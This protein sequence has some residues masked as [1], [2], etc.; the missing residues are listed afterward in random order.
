MLNR[1]SKASLRTLSGTR[2]LVVLLGGQTVAALAGLAY[3]KLTA[4]Y[5]SPAEWGD[6]SLLFVA[7]TLLHSLF[8]TPTLQWFKAAL[9]QFSPQQVIPFV[10]KTLGMIYISIGL[11]TAAIAGFYSQNPIFGLIWIAAV[12]QGIYQASSMYLNAL[13]RHWSYVLLQAGYAFGA[14]ILFGLI[15]LSFNQRTVSGLW[16]AVALGNVISAAVAIGYVIRTAKT[17]FAIT[18]PNPMAL[19]RAYRQY[20]WP[21]LSLAFWGWLINYADRY[22]IHL[23]L[24][25]ADVGQYTMGYSLGSKLLLLV[26]PLLAFLSPQILRIRATNQ[27]PETANLLI[28]HYLIRYLLLAGSGC[29]LFYAGRDWI[30]QILLSNRYAP[31]FPVGP[32]VAIGY[33]FLTSIHLLELKW[34]AYGQTHYVLWHNVSG[35]MLNIGFNVLLI[36]RLGILGAAVATLLGFT[37]QFLLAV[38]L[39][40]YTKPVS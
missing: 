15:V 9:A 29:L 40:F 26:A 20:V 32:I 6:Y 8:I 21:L 19:R 14:V 27:S 4:V 38:V 5:I 2:S 17:D 24:T 34:Y 3:G 25:D 11:L 37:G 35:A 13:G 1:V 18:I 23:Y 7:M 30:G 22:L 39:F 36:P 12:G 33:L 31:T 28:R 10:C 16:Q